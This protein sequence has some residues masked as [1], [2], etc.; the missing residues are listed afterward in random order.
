MKKGENCL[1]RVRELKKF[2]QKCAPK[3]AVVSVTSV[4]KVTLKKQILQMSL[5]IYFFNS[6]VEQREVH[7][8]RQ[9]S[10]LVGRPVTG[11]LCLDGGGGRSGLTSDLGSLTAYAL[12]SEFST[13]LQ[14]QFV[15]S[16]VY[17]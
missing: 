14:T 15:I 7:F 2:E 13:E 9:R 6:K 4:P 12:T 11:I 1:P 16:F 8:H 10:W 3:S 17:S 5:F